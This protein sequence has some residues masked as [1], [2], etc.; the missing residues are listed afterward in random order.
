MEL[1]KPAVVFLM[2]TKMEKNHA[3]GLKHR[4]GFPN[5]VAVGAVGQSGGLALFWWREVMVEL[6]NLSKSHIDVLISCDELDNKQWWFTGFYGEPRREFRK[7]SWYL[8]QFL[9]AQLDFP[10]LYAGDF[11]KILSAEE[12]FG[13]NDRELW[14]MAG[15]QDVVADCG[16][17]DLGYRGLP[18]T[19]FIISKMVI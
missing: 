2:E 1:Y 15:F 16:F 17:V 12:Q 18:Y 9:H 7:D 10:W 5:S 11:N 8:L 13:G 19:W 3:L 14:Q 4:L 6:Q